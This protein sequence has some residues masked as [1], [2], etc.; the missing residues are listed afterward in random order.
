MLRNKLAV[1]VIGV[2]T[3]SLV[4]GGG[5]GYWIAH[6]KDNPQST[7][8]GQQQDAKVLYWYDPMK[9]E[10]H[11]DKPGKSPFMDMQLVPKYAD[12]NTAMTD[13]SRPTVKIDPSLQQNL[14]IRYGTV[15]QAVIG[16][17]MFTN[18]I[19]QANE[20]QTAILQTRASGFV[21]RV[22][23]HAVGDMVTEGSPIADISIPEWTGEQTEFLAVLR[24]GDRSLIQASRQ[25]LQLLGI[26]QNVIH[27]VER[28]RRVQSNIT[29]QAPISGFIDSLEV[30]NGMAL[31]MGQTLATIKGINPIWLEAAVP[32][33]QIAGI[34]R[35]M[36]VE[37]NFAAFSQKVTGK[38]IDILPTLDTTSR[39]IKVRIEL[40][41]P[42]GQLKPGMFASVNIINNPQSSLVVP[43]QAVIRT[44]TRNVVIVGREQG[45]FKPVVVQLGQSDGNKIAVL[46]GLKAGQRVVISG[47]FLI[48]SEANLQGILDKL[49]TGQPITS[50]QTIKRST[51]Q[52]LGKVEKV[53]NQDITI[54]H[55]AI[56]ELGWG[57]MTMI[58][59]QP[60]Q[61][62]TRI[63]QGDQV[64]FSFTKVG[65]SYVISDISKMSMASMKN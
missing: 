58:F 14:A 10:Q 59:K 43:E 4:A 39:T 8:A 38:V 2:A 65:N 52:G 42:S 19:L 24:T 18:G 48:D 34:K 41:N 56:P 22:Y 32:E 57:A 13:E 44:G 46:Q 15:E 17:A 63:Q 37:A 20:R 35:G 3:I 12:E 47:Q 1:T 23:G 40:P 62:F 27:Q 11:F 16:N 33:K 31:A 61:P 26:P 36:S 53:T 5:A 55:Q 60:V 50:S 7:L 28:T 29:L 54:S 51:Y 9:P 21:Q 30:R 45:R 49:N 6:Q 64:N 25:R